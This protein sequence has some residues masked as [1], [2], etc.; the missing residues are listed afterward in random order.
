MIPVAGFRALLGH[1]AD[2]LTD[3]KVE[4]IGAIARVIE[5]YS[6]PEVSG[7]ALLLENKIARYAD[8]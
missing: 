2:P 3:A 7:T 1:L 8:R 5:L 4:H 6:Q